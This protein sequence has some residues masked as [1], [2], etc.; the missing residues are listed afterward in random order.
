MP[1]PSRP[2]VVIQPIVQSSVIT[3]EEA[4]KPLIITSPNAEKF[5]DF[6]TKFTEVI[7]FG[8]AMIAIWT[9]LI[10]IAF[11]DDATN[12]N[13]LILFVGGLISSMI[14]LA[15]VEF[16]SK[17]NQYLLMPSQNY[18]LGISF[19]FMAV[20][21]LWGIRFLAGWLTYDSPI[22]DFDIFGPAIANEGDWI[23]NANLI[24]A[25]AAGSILL[26]LTQQRLLKRY[27]GELTFSWTVTC[28]IPLAL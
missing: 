28:F 22:N 24:Y 4:E 21:L 5:G 9:G 10:G 13:Y 6:L 18:L 14:A 17:K 8:I 26:V 27:S 7:M 3:S 15:M 11:S 2:Q 1:A 12:Y 25:Q 23:P 19:F 20:G 16:S